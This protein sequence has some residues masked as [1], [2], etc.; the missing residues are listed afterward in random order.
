MQVMQIN[1]HDSDINHGMSSSL[2]DSGSANVNKSNVSAGASSK[3]FG[4]K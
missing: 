3:L 4:T 2:M 1:I